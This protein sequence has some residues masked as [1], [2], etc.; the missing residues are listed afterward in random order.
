MEIS[1]RSFLKIPPVRDVEPLT[2]YSSVRGES[3][4][5]D[6]D[7]RN[8]RFCCRNRKGRHVTNGASAVNCK[9]LGFI[10][11]CHNPNVT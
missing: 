3:L 4:C 9:C 6:G 2:P 1:L 10:G 8:P 5:Q 7:E 11:L